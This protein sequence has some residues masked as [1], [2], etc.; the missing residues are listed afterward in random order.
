MFNPGKE[1]ED[2]LEI[3]GPERGTSAAGLADRNPCAGAPGGG[4]L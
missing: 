3:H 1:M 2:G 4:R